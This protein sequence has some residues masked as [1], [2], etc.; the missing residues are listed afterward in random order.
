MTSKTIEEKI[1]EKKELI[2]II[3]AQI[4]ITMTAFQKV[5]AVFENLYTANHGK[6]NSHMNGIS[7][8][9]DTLTRSIKQKSDIQDEINR[10]ES[11]EDVEV[12]ET[13]TEVTGNKDDFLTIIKDASVVEQ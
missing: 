2:K 7:S 11:L 6:V 10:L 3:D 8:L 1:K 5:T 13:P 9:S 12:E 4:E